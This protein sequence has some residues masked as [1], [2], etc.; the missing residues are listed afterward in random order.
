M[1]KFRKLRIKL[2][3]IEGLTGAKGGEIMRRQMLEKRVRK[4][5]GWMFPFYPPGGRLSS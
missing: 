2:M 1:I 5:A 3:I 4:D